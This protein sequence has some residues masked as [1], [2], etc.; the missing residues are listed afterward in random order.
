VKQELISSAIQINFTLKRVIQL[1]TLPFPLSL[2]AIRI[3]PDIFAC[4]VKVKERGILGK[5]YVAAILI[6][7]SD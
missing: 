1:N 7:S 2:S 6:V 5:N 3:F 4:V